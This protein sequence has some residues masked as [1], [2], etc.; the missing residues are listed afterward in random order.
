MPTMYGDS[1][2]QGV[3]RAQELE[4]EIKKAKNLR[5]IEGERFHVAWDAIDEINRQLREAPPPGDRRS[6]TA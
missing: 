5:D 1:P 3:V 2:D 6:L 4:S